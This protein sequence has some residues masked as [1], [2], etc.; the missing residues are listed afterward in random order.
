MKLFHIGFLLVKSGVV[1]LG[2]TENKA[3]LSPCKLYDSLDLIMLNTYDQIV[4]EY[5][6]ETKFLKRLKRSQ[7][8]WIQYRD[9]QMKMYW[10]LNKEEYENWSYCKCS[11]LNTFTVNRIN[12]LQQWLDGQSS[13]DFCDTSIKNIDE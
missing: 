8:Y 3:E 9:A 5:K 10:P 12:E 2:C 7:I 6:G 13:T 11:E 1:L 4:E